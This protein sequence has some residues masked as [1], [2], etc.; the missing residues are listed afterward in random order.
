MKIIFYLSSI[1]FLFKELQWLLAPMKEVEK[2]K[3]REK[4][5]E[6]TKNIKYDLLSKEQKNG[7]M[8]MII[9]FIFIFGWMFVGLFTFQWQI[10]LSFLLLQ[11]IIIAPI[12]KLFKYSF[13]YTA[14]HWI[15]SLVAFCFILF[16]IINSYHLKI[17]I[18]FINYFR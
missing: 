13:A 17:D 5:L 16:T 14:L 3:K 2:S 8:T 4:L 12:S 1:V 15:N 18:D 9:L 11:F 10:F 6:S 7:I